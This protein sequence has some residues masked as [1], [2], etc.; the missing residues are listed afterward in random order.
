MGGV[1]VRNVL[2]VLVVPVVATSSLVVL[3]WMLG[4]KG[5]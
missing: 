4:E 1:I 2:G 5:D 3:S